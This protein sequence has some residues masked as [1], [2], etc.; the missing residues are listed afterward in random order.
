M[1][2]AL[3]KTRISLVDLATM[4]EADVID[5]LLELAVELSEIALEAGKPQASALLTLA[6]S[7]LRTG[8]GGA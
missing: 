8:T 6:A 1:N 4:E 5:Y 2:V 7:N 3:D